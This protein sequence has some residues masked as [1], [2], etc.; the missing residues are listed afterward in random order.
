[1]FVDKKRTQMISFFCLGIS[2]GYGLSY[3]ISSK[4][5]LYFSNWQWA[6][7]ITPG[8]GIT[9]AILLIIIFKEPERGGKEDHTHIEDINLKSSLFGDLAYL[10]KK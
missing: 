9:L 10:I 4:I 5:S 2:I 7:R 8:I 1:M 6:L 3:M